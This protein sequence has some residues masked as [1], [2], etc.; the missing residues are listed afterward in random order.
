MHRRSSYSCPPKTNGDFRSGEAK[1]NAFNLEPGKIGQ[2]IV[3]PGFSV[4]SSV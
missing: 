2:S 3:S 1:S 4:A